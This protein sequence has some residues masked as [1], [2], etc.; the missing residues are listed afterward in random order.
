MVPNHHV[1]RR[2]QWS[3][4]KQDI[5]Q[6]RML[7]R[8]HTFLVAPRIFPVPYALWDV[9]SLGCHSKFAQPISPMVATSVPGPHWLQEPTQSPVPLPSLMSPWFVQS[10]DLASHW[11]TPIGQPTHPLQD[12]WHIHAGTKWLT[13][14]RWHFQVCFLQWKGL[15]FYSNFTEFVVKGGNVNKSVMVQVMV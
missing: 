15:K 1:F 9:Q 6:H 14:C 13:F 11:P 8:N 4:I 5:L 3:V 2:G 10:H 7:H 12:Y